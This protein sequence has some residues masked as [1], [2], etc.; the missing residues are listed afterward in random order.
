MPEHELVYVAGCARDKIERWRTDY[1]EFRPY[2]ATSHLTPAEFAQKT[3][4]TAV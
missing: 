2:S 3:G 1:N 4:S